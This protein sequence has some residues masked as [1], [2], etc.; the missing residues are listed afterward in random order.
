M[1]I[2][3]LSTALLLLLLNCSGN[4]ED[5]GSDNTQNPANQSTSVGCSG[6]TYQPWHESDYVLPYPVGR[7]YQVHLSQCSSSYHSQ[8]QPDQFAVDFGM[9]IGTLITASR[10]GLVVYTEESGIDGDFPNNLVVVKHSDNSYA[11]YMHLTHNGAIPE[12]GDLVEQ[13]DS[14]G[15]SGSTGL[16]GYPHLHFVVTKDRW[17][18]PYESIPHNYR[19][20]SPNPRGPKSQHEYTAEPY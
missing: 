5:S 11:Q 12:I 7:T 18:Y 9:A 16:A 17:E 1:N 13:G 20:T 19:N 8:G 2:S 14:I 3:I 4:D 15:Y 10:G 6:V